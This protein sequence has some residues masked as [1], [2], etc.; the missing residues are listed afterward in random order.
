MRVEFG[1]TV[2]PIPSEPY[3]K[4]EGMINS[5]FPPLCIPR[6][7]SFNPCKGNILR[8]HMKPIFLN[9]KKYGFKLNIKD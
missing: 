9:C 6:M 7:P 8:S 5:L 1:G 2:A 4:S 3:A